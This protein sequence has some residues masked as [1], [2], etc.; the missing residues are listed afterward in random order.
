[1]AGL[2]HAPNLLEEAELRFEIG[3]AL[4][5]GLLEARANQT[6]VDP[7]LVVGCVQARF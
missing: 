2:A 7:L 4:C 1:M 3:Q 6:A 5:W